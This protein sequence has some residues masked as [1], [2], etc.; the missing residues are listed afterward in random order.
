MSDALDSRPSRYRLLVL[1]LLS[2]VWLVQAPAFTRYFAA[3]P[4]DVVAHC[5][6]PTPR[7][8]SAP[9]TIAEM[10]DCAER[11]CTADSGT[12][13]EQFDLYCGNE[14][15][16]GILGVLIFLGIA[17]GAVFGS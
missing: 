11:R 4:Y 10:C 5:E 7:N 13:A 16:N 12:I 17:F 9:S 6:C 14:V 15:Y 2:A 8:T 3:L 1:S